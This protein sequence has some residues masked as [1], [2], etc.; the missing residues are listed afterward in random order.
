MNSGLSQTQE[1]QPWQSI[2]NIIMAGTQLWGL[3][4]LLQIIQITCLVTNGLHVKI[5]T[6]STYLVGGLEHF[7]FFH[8][9][10]GNHSPNWLIFFRGVGQ[11]PSYI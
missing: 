10:G 4:S 3:L 1:P 11:P 5:G 7:L 2:H 9:L 6:Y 8:I